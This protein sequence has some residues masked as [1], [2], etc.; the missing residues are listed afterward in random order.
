MIRTLLVSILIV[1]IMG[2]CKKTEAEKET[3]LVEIKETQLEKR[4]IIE[5]SK[6]DENY[7]SF[8]HV[9]PDRILRADYRLIY[10]GKYLKKA[11]IAGD[12][13]ET[14]VNFTSNMLGLITLANFDSRKS[15]QYDYDIEGRLV[16]VKRDY[17]FEYEYNGRNLSKATVKNSN[18][19]KITETSITCDDKVN[20]LYQIPLIYL[21][22]PIAVWDCFFL[23][24][25]NIIGLET[26]HFNTNG[27]AVSKDKSLFEYSYDRQNRPVKQERSYNGISNDY[28]IFEYTY[29]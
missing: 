24:K 29:Q 6:D 1:F 20:P 21:E 17:I 23:S 7:F 10:E 14:V 26:T 4:V 8:H 12:F 15:I 16:S 13:S 25:N 19:I 2:S 5:I 9:Y 22:E 27:A 18:G 3:K 11:K 28:L